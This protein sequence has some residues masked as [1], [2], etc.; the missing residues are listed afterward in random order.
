MKALRIILFAALAAAQLAVPGWMVIRQELTLR[1]GRSFKLRTAPVDPYDAF[2]GRFVALSFQAAAVPATEPWQR[3]QQVFAKL[4]EGTDGFATVEELVA[5]PTAGANDAVQV[6]VGWYR[7]VFP[8]DRYYLEE[9]KAPA[10]EEAYRIAS[11]A[12]RPA[13]VTIRVRNGYAAIEEL[14]IDGK[15]ILQYLRDHPPAADR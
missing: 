2:R 11:R 6:E 1:D 15:P 13:W 4:R 7:V 5:R 14:F 9:S 10:A 12:E 8:F 3:G